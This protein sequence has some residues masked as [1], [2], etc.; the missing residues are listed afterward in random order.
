MVS[1]PGPCVSAQ[2]ADGPPC[3]PPAAAEA[4]ELELEL[5]YEP[6]EEGEGEE[7]E[8]QEEEAPQEGGGGSSDGQ[9]GERAEPQVRSSI[10]LSC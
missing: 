5:D 7:Y 1:M 4:D 9:A 8:E 10:P 3:R 6:G 2:P